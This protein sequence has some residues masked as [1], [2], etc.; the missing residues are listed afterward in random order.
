MASAP[1]RRTSGSATLAVV[2]VYRQAPYGMQDTPPHGGR[3]VLIL[4]DYEVANLQRLLLAVAGTTSE[5]E[6]MVREFNNGDWVGQIG[7]YLP[8]VDHAPNAPYPPGWAP[9][10]W[11]MA[12][13]YT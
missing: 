12:R 11:L 5:G 7:F 8:D 1:I 13:K 6:R 2:R 9:P 3:T 10:G 4:D